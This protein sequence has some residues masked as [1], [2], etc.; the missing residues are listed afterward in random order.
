MAA[1]V[2]AGACNCVIDYPSAGRIS[3]YET[4]DLSWSHPE[5]EGHAGSVVYL[6]QRGFTDP[7]NL[8]GKGM[9][10]EV[11]I[12]GESGYGWLLEHFGMPAY[13]L[14]MWFLISFYRYLKLRDSGPDQMPL[15][16]EAM[17]VATFVVMHFSYYPFAFIGWIPI[18]YFFGLS[19]AC[20]RVRIA[21]PGRGIES[22]AG[23]PQELLPEADGHA[24][25]NSGE[26]PQPS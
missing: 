15:L 23:G 18:W 20:P 19:V 10:T 24:D 26:A 25:R 9:R 13:L 22:A 7:R 2:G 21:A 6:Y 17:I 8:L 4:Q 5:P 3:H 1:G 16:A 14:W 12:M 11:E